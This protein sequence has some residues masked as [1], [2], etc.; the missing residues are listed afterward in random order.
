MGTIG[1]G[2]GGA[3]VPSAQPPASSG[4]ALTEGEVSSAGL[5]ATTLEGLAPTLSLDNSIGAGVSAWLNNKRITGLWAI[6]QTRNSWINVNGVGWKK[7]ANNSDSAIASLTML[8]AHA[9]EKA[10]VVNYR[11]E[12]DAMVHEIYVW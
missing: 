1:N 12:S 8:S 2:N 6:N 9:Y 4:S 10:A 11:E 3:S 5:S 7:L